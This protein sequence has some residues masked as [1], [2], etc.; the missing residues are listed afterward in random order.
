M[1]KNKILNIIVI[2]DIHFGDKLDREL[3][4]ALQERFFPAINETTDAVII[5]GDLFHKILKLNES[6]CLYAF[7]FI[8]SLIK[9]STIYNF[10][11]RIIK[12]TKSHDFN[13]L[14]NFK[15]YENQYDFKI[16]ETVTEEELFKNHKVL[17]IPEEYIEN[18]KDYYKDYFNKTYNSIFF[19]GTM[20]F[21]AY[22]SH[23]KINKEG[24][25]A[26]NFSSEKIAKLAI[27]GII[28]GHI[29][30]KQNYM[31][32]I[33]YTGS[34]WRTKFGESEDKA[35][36]QYLYNTKNDTFKIN[37]IINDL[38]PEYITIN[39]KDIEG[40][41]EE[42]IKLIEELKNEYENIR[43]DVDE[44]DTK[45]NNIIL[46]NLNILTDENIK[47]KVNNNFKEEY[48]NKYDFILNKELP[49][50]ETI[51]KF[52]QLMFNKDL[53]IETINKFLNEEN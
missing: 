15:K 27:G 2:S 50:N 22:S 3:Y 26:P 1:I 18:E 30:I 51:K 17:Y 25:N 46:E 12:G 29:H 47:I 7:N 33:F 34:F 13:Q 42:K 23:V 45:G 43:I 41:L 5:A 6:S 37:Y 36:I 52:S 24:K 32:K 16:I 38:A 8:E 14:N 31:N 28:G 48:D 11:I 20:N 19:H 53:K 49:L 40:T 39:F 4:D 35:F 44:E 21:A 10:K 9:L